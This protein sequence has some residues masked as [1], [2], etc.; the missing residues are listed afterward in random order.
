[1]P[2]FLISALR[3]IVEM[4]GL[5]LMGQGV[6]YLLTGSRRQQNAIYRFFDLVTRPPRQ[7]VALFLPRSVSGMLVGLL[8]FVLLLMLWIGL[9]WL[10]KSF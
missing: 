6:L 3:A 9:A 4:L 8:S 1:M 10:R 7:F 5:C 2:V